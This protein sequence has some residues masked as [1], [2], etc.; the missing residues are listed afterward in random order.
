MI[1][2][3]LI[4]VMILTMIITVIIMIIKINDNYIINQFIYLTIFVS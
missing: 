1:I 4:I 2:I 3:I